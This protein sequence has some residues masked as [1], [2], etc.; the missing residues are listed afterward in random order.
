MK[1]D[2]K[3]SS[4]NQQR[5]EKEP[6][7]E[8][9]H[10]EHCECGC[11]HDHDE[12][13]HEHYH[14]NQQHDEHCDCGGEHDHNEHS[15]EHYHDNQQHDKHCDCGGEHD[16]NEHSHAHYHDNQQHDEHCGCGC[17]H[18]HDGHSHAHYHD[19]HQHDEH[20]GCGSQHDHDGHSHAHYHDDH[21]HDEH[22]GCGSQHD[23]DGHSHAHYHD[24]HQHDEHCGCGSQHDHN[25]HSHAHY[26]DN[27]QHDEHCDCGCEHDYG[28]EESHHT[29]GHPKD[30]QC[31]L[32]HPHEEYCDICG[33]SLAN[34]KC[35]M[36]DADCE[37]KVYILKNLGCANC[38]A[39]MEAKIKELPGVEYATI[40]FATNQL[41][42]SARDHASLLPRIQEICTSI[43]S[44][45]E[46]VPRFK[47]PG[48]FTTK[49]Y[50]IENLGCAHCASKM[51]EKINALPEVSNATLTFATHQLR[52]TSKRDPDILLNQ[53]QKIC[54]DI[55]SGVT[56][57]AKDTTPKSADTLPIQDV[58]PPT[59]VL[60]QDTKTILALC[61]GAALFVAGEV[62][63]HMG[64]EIPSL[65]VLLTA[66]VLLG[67]RIVLTALRN[68]AKGHVFDENFLMSVATIGAIVIREYPEAV[69]VMLFYRIG[70]YFE[71]KA[72]E[73][74]RS[75][76]MDAVDMRPETVTLVI[77]DDTKTIAAG[78]AVVGD[79][80]LIRPGDRIP[81]DS[82]VIEGE[83]RIDTS[84]VTGEPVPVKAGFGDELTSGCV[85]TSG[86]LKVRVEKILEESMVTRILDSVEN[87]AA[88]KPKIDRFITR[89]ARV[90]TPFV[91][92]LALATAVIP[93]L[94]T[95]DWDHWVYTALTFLVISCPCALVLS[96]PLAFFS[97]IGAGSKRGILF[98]GGVSL[99]AMKGVN[100]VIMDKTG[101]LTEG[102]FVLQ[103]VLP[104]GHMNADDLLELCAACESTS[105][106]P[107]ANSIVTAAQGK[108]LPIKRPDSVE[109]IAGCGIHAFINGSEIL[110]G[111]R[112]LME[113][114]HI[115]MEN[116]ST[117]GL[118]A[119]VFA[120]KDKTY[121][122][123]LVIADTLKGDAKSAVKKIKDMGIT[124]AMLTGDAQ[125]TALAVAKAA[126]IE[127]VR[128]RLLPQDKLNELTRL[129]NTYGSVMFVGDGIN[130]APVLA[131]ADVG[132]A[133]GSGADAAIEAADVV[134]MNSSM[135]A[136]PQALSIARATSR[137]SWQNVIFALIIKV[138]VM[139]LGLFGF[140]SMW[141]AVFADTGVAILCVLN[142]IRILYRKNLS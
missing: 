70:E 53:I 74:S 12:H 51:E 122:G 124:P 34:C 80:I 106:H 68:L 64:M 79:I 111:N 99:E 82:V 132:A 138:L 128:A 27:H 101:T 90:Y 42:L 86:L 112:K 38:A 120:V 108:G 130:D 136:V 126:G 44:Q 131:G 123:C 137:I 10:D 118:G 9:L 110:C 32:C 116:I 14:D 129:R 102:N 18:D 139:I 49:T 135:E 43:E 5:Y 28:H 113:K 92:F 17:G 11:G 66:Y 55:E 93:S 141:M 107:I 87:A 94:I 140:A 89:F 71:H 104:A 35:N 13:S 15:H 50:R 127:E 39:K 62:L 121:V 67:G 24:D 6:N 21:Q 103:T 83:S 30:C 25:G 133:M 59:R 56:I 96:V 2:K 88:S 98:K 26:H 78:D 45:V 61:T 75:Q 115:P 40:T 76:I 22:C 48:A 95:G 16:H 37:K 81:L 91:V 114:F 31:E 29:P 142:S 60:S 8:H 58:V 19:D 4:I 85:N 97:G 7:H 46:V 23:H 84:P 69:G 65:A 20:C 117:D 47:M 105:S 63:E 33:E 134:F 52:V 119:E 3:N 100:A 57:K 1:Q 73:R 77:G 41:R 72:V 109:E 54:T 125:E 36:P